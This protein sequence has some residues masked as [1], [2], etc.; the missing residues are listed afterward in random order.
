MARAAGPQAIVTALAVAE[1]RRTTPA[2]K[3]AAG[4]EGHDDGEDRRLGEVTR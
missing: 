1:M 4:K 2:P 3:S